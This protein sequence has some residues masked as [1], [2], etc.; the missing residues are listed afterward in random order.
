MQW[1]VKNEQ[2]ALKTFTVGK[3]RPGNWHLG[4]CLGNPWGS[5]YGLSTIGFTS[6]VFIEY[7]HIYCLGILFNKSL[8]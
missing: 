5:P 3:N 8:V 6:T 1:V 7:S 2:E 4:G